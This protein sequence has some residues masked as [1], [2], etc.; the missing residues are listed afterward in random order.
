MI[1]LEQ[2][3]F[4]ILDIRRHNKAF[5]QNVFIL[6]NLEWKF[7][8]NFF[9]NGKTNIEYYGETFEKVNSPILDLVNS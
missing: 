2:M 5:I 7:S 9:H 3:A 6:E 1:F 8:K 4:K